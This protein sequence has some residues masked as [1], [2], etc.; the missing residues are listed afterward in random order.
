MAFKKENISGID[1][2]SR[3]IVYVRC[4]PEDKVISNICIQPLEQGGEDYW[5]SV[6][7]GFDQFIRKFSVPGEDVVSCLPADYALI[8]KIAVDSD[9]TDPKEI[10][11]WE[12]SQQMIGSV[13]E[14]VYDYQPL[15][16]TTNTEKQHFLVVGYRNTAVAKLNKILKAKKLNPL[17]L[18]LDI[19][20]LVNVFELNYEERISAPAL[21]IFSDGATIK[22]VLTLQG[23]FVDCEIL[24]LP[25]D[26]HT[27]EGFIRIVS[28]VTNTIQGCNQH[29]TGNGQMPTFFTGALFSQSEFTARVIQACANSELLNPLKKI[30]CTAGMDEAKLREYGTYLAVSV[31]LAFRGLD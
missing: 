25:P 7:A 17:V 27:E 2:N 3:N 14:Y 18:D 21:I 13:S 26:A 30:S 11:E 4:S 24:D 28:D 20:A 23:E 29:M 8:K 16:N 9:E 19:F 1:I 6:Q 31:G 22:A 12:L 10:I 5:K 15:I